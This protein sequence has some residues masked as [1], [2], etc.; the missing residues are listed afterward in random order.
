MNSSGA[1]SKWRRRLRDV[2]ELCMD[3]GK[4]VVITSPIRVI[5]EEIDRQIAFMTLRAR[6]SRS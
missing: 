4:F 1:I 2:Y 5:P 3:T 6:I